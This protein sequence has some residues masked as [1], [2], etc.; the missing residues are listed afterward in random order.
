MS[1]DINS[2]ALKI[3]GINCAANS[4]PEH[5][6]LVFL[7]AKSRTVKFGSAHC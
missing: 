6:D 2:A 5:T 4:F 3:A 1:T 7:L